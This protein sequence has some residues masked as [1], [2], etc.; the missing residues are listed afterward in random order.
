MSKTPEQYEYDIGQGLALLTEGWAE[1]GREIDRLRTALAKAEKERDHARACLPDLACRLT[2]AGVGDVSGRHCTD[3]DPCVSCDRDRL[4]ARVEELEARCADISLIAGAL[5]DM[6][7]EYH[8]EQAKRVS[9]ALLA[10]QM[11]SYKKG[12]SDG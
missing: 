7:G 4:A 5:S 9:K 8:V 6:P 11:V 10:G 3:S 1:I 2:A 12:E